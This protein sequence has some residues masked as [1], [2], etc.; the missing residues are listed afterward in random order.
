ME[1]PDLTVGDLG[2]PTECESVISGEHATRLAATLDAPA[3]RPGEPLPLLWQWAWFTPMTPTAGLGPDGHP[4]LAPDGP[5][6]AYP[7]RMWVG[8]RVRC[9]EPLVVGTAVTRRS[10]M[11]RWKETVGESG[12]LLIATVEHSYEQAGR[13]AIVEEQDLAYRQ[14]GPAIPLPEGNHVETPAPGGWK[15]VVSATLP[16]LFRFSAV[17]FNS[18]RIHYDESYAREIEG[19]PAPVVHG[20]LTA[21]LLAALASPTTGSGLAT[22]EFRATAPLFCGLPFCLVVEPGESGTIQARAV[23]NDGVVAMSATAIHR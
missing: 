4:A 21:M 12:G 17:T 13:L 6:A 16:L 15:K 2:L 3:P 18:H 11:L 7:R 20:P 8:G 23:R 22:F 14:A 19:Y 5:T 10:R 1:Q 9:T